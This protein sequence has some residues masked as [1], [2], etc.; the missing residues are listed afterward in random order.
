MS[1]ND[2][3]ALNRSEL[4]NARLEIV[5]SY[6][7][8]TEAGL[9]IHVLTEA[10]IEAKPGQEA[11]STWMWHWGSALG[12]G[13]HVLVLQSDLEEATRILADDHFPEEEVHRFAQEY[14]PWLDEETNEDED[15]EKEPLHLNHALLASIVGTIVLPPFIAFYSIYLIFKYQIWKQEQGGRYFRFYAAIL[16]NL[17]SIL[18]GILIYFF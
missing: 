6:P 12:G 8:A 13:V 16:L 7:S 1:D 15:L 17:F 3:N 10:G 14:E 2:Q 18:F 4:D 11:T 5:A 9:A